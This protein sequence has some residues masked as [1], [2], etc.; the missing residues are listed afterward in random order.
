MKKFIVT[1][2]LISFISTV[3]SYG[4]KL[5]T[6]KT[7]DRTVPSRCSGPGSESYLDDG[8]TKTYYTPGQKTTYGGPYTGYQAVTYEKYY[9]PILSKNIRTE[10]IG[11]T[12]YY[13]D[14]TVQ[15]PGTYTV[16]KTGAIKTKDLLSRRYMREAA[17]Y[18]VVDTI[19]NP[20]HAVE[21]KHEEYI[22]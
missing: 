22:E 12:W 14:Y 5:I 13:P 8:V 16:E 9:K 11:T 7:T 20:N 1:L 2:L 19:N 3:P 17:D 10:L 6:N 21:A 4:M 15:T 18:Y